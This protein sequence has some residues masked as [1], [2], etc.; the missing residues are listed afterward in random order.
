MSLENL[1]DNTRAGQR[2]P[3]PLANS[4][5]S[6]C[7]GKEINVLVLGKQSSGKSGQFL[8][9]HTLSFLCFVKVANQIKGK[10]SAITRQSLDTCNIFYLTN[11]FLIGL[12]ENRA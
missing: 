2:C 4:K 8:R 5:Q 9:N 7:G 12:F 6:N 3:K 10:I 1:L 11:V